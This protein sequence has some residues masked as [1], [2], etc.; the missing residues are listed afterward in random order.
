MTMEEMVN[1]VKTDFAAPYDKFLPYLKNK[2][3]RFRHGRP[4][5]IE[6]LQG[7]CRISL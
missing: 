3:P 4:D 1:A 6:Q 7:T 5:C 2:I